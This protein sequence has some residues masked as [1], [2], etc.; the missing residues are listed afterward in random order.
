MPG[1]YER[2]SYLDNSFLA[3]ESR[4]TH[5]HVA[6]I[7][8]FEA[9][10]LRNETGG[11]DTDRIR[12][13]VESKLHLIPRY[14]QRLAWVPIE[15]HPT[16][17]DDEHFNIEYHVR[18]YSLPRPGTFDQLRALIGIIMSQQLDRSKPLWE[19][20]VVEGLEGDR[21]ALVSKIH[22]CMIDGVAGVDLMAVLL[23]LAPTEELIEPEPFVPRPVP[24]GSELL[25]R[26]TARRTGRAMGA[27]RSVRQLSADASSLLGEGVHRT[28]A[29][30]YSLSSGWL[31]N[32]SRSPVNGK[33]GPNRLFG[34]LQTPLSKVKDLKNTV[35]GSVNDVVLAT[36]A[37]GVRRF[38]TE[39]RDFD[40]TGLDFRSMAPVSVRSHDQRGTMGNQVAM[41]LVSLPVSEPDPLARLQSV[42]EST[43]HLKVTDQA[44]GAA[45]L[46]RLSAGAPATL[47]S[48]A[49]RLA[50]GVRP[51][52]MTVTN[53][54]G[55]QFPLF[56]LGSP[57]VES[58]PL[59]PLWQTHGIGVALFSYAGTVYW[60]LN[61]DYDIVPDVDEFA[62][63]LEFAFDELHEAAMASGVDTS[64]PK[65]PKKR[66]P[67]GKTP[68]GDKKPSATKTAKKKPATKKTATKKTATKKT[69][70]AGGDAK[71]SAAAEEG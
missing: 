52:N 30:G 26:E 25:V 5:M 46:V 34:T 57:M 12:R 27:M 3:L 7:A 21:F 29:A 10:P 51:F 62:A 16:W 2:L 11:I 59:V 69:A 14:R 45:T 35:G 48:M 37:G 38:L 43:E 50:S 49:S 8:I 19:F 63:A 6:G 61:A 56:L 47:V 24:S 28:K 66:P 42:R 65:Q 9:E 32:T 64:V 67:L 71:A 54:P 22:H 53:V 41:W 13:L 23:N 68:S 17:V 60:G 55:P 39:E 20:N 40:V 4:S 15:K 33:V 36:V 44:L 70:A 58:Y 18:H 31:T 1:H